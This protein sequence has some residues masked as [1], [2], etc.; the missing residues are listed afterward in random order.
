MALAM[1]QKHLRVQG[2]RSHAGCSTC[3]VRH[4]KCDE[5]MPACQR[6]LKAGR[7]CDYAT[8]NVGAKI[9]EA[10]ARF[11]VYVAPQE[12]F[13][14]PGLSRAESRA[15]HHFQHKTAPEVTGPFHSELW[16]KLILQL[17]HHNASIRH[18]VL[19]LSSMHLVF[20]RLRD[21]RNEL[22][23][24]GMRNYNKA[25]RHFVQTPKLDHSFDE[26]LIS[27][28]LFC[29]IESLR[30]DFYQSLQH[31]LSGLKIIAEHHVSS[32]ARRLPSSIPSDLLS[33]AFLILQSQVMELGDPSV[34]RLYEDMLGRKTPIPDRISTFE[35]ALH[36][37]EVLMNELFRFL[38]DSEVLSKAGANDSGDIMTAIMPRYETLKARCDKWSKQI[39]QLTTPVGLDMGSRHEACLILKIHQ[40]IMN[41]FLQSFATG[42]MLDIFAGELA[43]VLSLVEDFLQSQSVG[44]ASTSRNQKAPPTFSMSLGVVPILFMIT[45]RC[46]TP[47]IRA[48]SQKL[49][50]TCNR[51]EGVWDSR[52]ASQLA[53]HIIALKNKPRVKIAEIRFLPE[54]NCLIKYEINA[55]GENESS[56]LPTS[57]SQQQ[58]GSEIVKI[59]S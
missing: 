25:I 28:I 4:V 14:L 51:R 41:I 50:E 29:A 12:P 18:S 43:D 46:D 45:W 16:S 21:D 40:T 9:D 6:C 47:A 1:P 55:A 30:G 5:G 38:E 58:E 59:I 33:K 44:T 57:S 3:R 52:V 24:D 8:L 36:H 20:W 27:C 22:Y 26:L 54:R 17:C 10:P 49:L 11:V 23:Q 35:E 15:L 31:A 19:T 42:G 56:W 39:D 2:K 34:F 48:R 13:L 37:L 32:A 7:S 53:V